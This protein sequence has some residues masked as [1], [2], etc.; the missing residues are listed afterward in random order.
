MDKKSKKQI[1]ENKEQEPTG[2]T[3][4]E[5]KISDGDSVE[6]SEA[7]AAL[8]AGRPV[9]KTVIAKEKSV[10]GNILSPGPQAKPA[11]T[12]ILDTQPKHQ[13]LSNLLKNLQKGQ[14][15]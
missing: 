5:F 7:G 13:V 1:T 8:A 4:R 15:Q 14:I 11:P 12:D 9:K 3:S 6:G 2:I 10:I